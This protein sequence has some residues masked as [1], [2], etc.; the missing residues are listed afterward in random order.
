MKLKTRLK[1]LLGVGDDAARAVG[2]FVEHGGLRL[3]PAALRRCTIEFKEDGLFFETAVRE[4]SRLV[5]RFGLSLLNSSIKY[6][7]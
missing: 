4:A 1:D 2:R 3:P 7:W 5:K 6:S